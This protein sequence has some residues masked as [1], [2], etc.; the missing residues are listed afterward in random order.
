M[1]GTKTIDLAAVAAE[2]LDPLPRWACQ[3][4]DASVQLVR[5]GLLGECRVARGCC[6][7]VG[8]QHS[9]VVMGDDCYDD[10]AGIVDPTLWSYRDD[11]DGVWVGSY[12]DGWHTPHGKGSIWQWG[13]PNTP[14]G[15]VVDLTP[16]KPWSREARLFLETLGPLDRQGW[17]SLAHAP[18]ERWPAGEIFDAMIESGFEALIPI[19]IVGM[20]TDR[21][22]SGLY[23][24]S[25][26]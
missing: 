11:V 26:D 13:R 6:S 17:A 19:D 12:A 23:L 24:P 14:T 25:G 16:R 20:T 7:G 2:V 18:V 10:G 4:H 1:A 8:G 3:C 5:S 22:P 21:N 9:W 15:E